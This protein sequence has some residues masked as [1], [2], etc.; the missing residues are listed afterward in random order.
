LV[1]HRTDSWYE[2]FHLHRD[3][4]GDAVFLAVAQKTFGFRMAFARFMYSTNP[5]HPARKAS[6]PLAAR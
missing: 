1:K 6:S 5:F 4:D 2:S 3:F